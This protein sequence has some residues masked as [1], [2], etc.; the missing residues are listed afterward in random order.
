MHLEENTLES[1]L[2][3]DGKIIKVYKDKAKLENDR[4]VT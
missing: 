2:I 3:Y 4:E 1:N